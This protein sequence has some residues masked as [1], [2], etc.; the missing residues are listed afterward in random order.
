[1]KITSSLRRR[2]ASSSPQMA[3]KLSFIARAALVATG[4]CVY[5]PTATLSCQPLPH[6][7]NRYPIL[8][9]S[10]QPPLYPANLLHM[11]KK[12]SFIARAALVATGQLPG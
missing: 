5:L 3:K 2:L 9:L 8:A 10:G 4:V 12:L 1:M 11:A 7:A 6:P